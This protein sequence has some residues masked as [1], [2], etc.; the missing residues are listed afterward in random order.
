MAEATVGDTGAMKA[1]RTC[2]KDAIVRIPEGTML[3]NV[4]SGGARRSWNCFEL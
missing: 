3:V 4:A 1:A 2:T